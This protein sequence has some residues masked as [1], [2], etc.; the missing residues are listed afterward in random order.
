MFVYPRCSAWTSGRADPPRTLTSTPPATSA[1][2][3]STCAGPAVA[4][5]DRL[6]QRRP[7]QPVHVIAVD[8]GVEEPAHDPRVSA[9]RCA[10]ESRPVVGVLAVDFRAAVEGELEQAWVVAD[11]ARRDQ[12][13]ALLGLVLGVDVGAGGH[14][15]ARG[16]ELV[17]ERSRDEAPIEAVLLS[18][19]AAAARQQEGGQ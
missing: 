7:P 8:P 3:V 11:L 16:H 14:E 12:I 6:V 13:G 19:L 18:A 4:Q 9:L 15:L 17:A 10:D 2:T 1:R 5:D